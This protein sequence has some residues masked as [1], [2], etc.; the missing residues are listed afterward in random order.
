VKE[1]Y[2]KILLAEF[3][4]TIRAILSLARRGPRADFMLK[5]EIQIQDDATS[6][7]DAVAAKIAA[8]WV[9]G[10]IIRRPSLHGVRTKKLRG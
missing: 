6:F 3:F 2:S 1:Y 8:I 5:A 7:P 9:Q 10:P 4:N